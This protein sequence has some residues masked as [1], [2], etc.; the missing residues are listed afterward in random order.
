MAVYVC[1]ICGYIYDESAGAPDT[2]AAP[3]TRWEDLPDSWVCPICSAPKSA[4]EQ[5]GG[6]EPEPVRKET[7][8]ASDSET[9]RITE[10][11]GYT[12]G[13]LS[14]IFSNLAKGAEKQ[15]LT[16]EQDLLTKLAEYYLAKRP[17]QGT[18]DLS[19]LRQDTE[20]DINGGLKE[21][22]ALSKEDSDRGSMRVL[23][24]AGKVSAMDKSILEQY[25]AKGDEMLKD[26]RLWVCSICGFV[27]VGEVPPAICPVCKVPSFKILEVKKEA[28]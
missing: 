15:C 22:M 25:E 26:T 3:G 10:S 8:A 12:A 17:D 14:D 2:G 20:K 1:S 13:E 4:F 11:A 5:Q 21:S 7:P 24:W 6:A 23:T 9:A 18:A 19:G 28:N 16:K 27:Y